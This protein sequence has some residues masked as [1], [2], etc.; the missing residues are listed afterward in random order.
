MDTPK[1][2]SLLKACIT[3]NSLKQ[4][5]LIHQKI[6]AL[7]LHHNIFLCKHLIN[8]YLSCHSFES[9][10]LVFQII[11]N[12]LDISL[13]NG[14]MASYT[15]N[16]M[17]S[18]ALQLFERLLLFPH[19]KPDNYTYPSVLK[20]C[21]GLA[22]VEN[23]KRIHTHVI[24]T[25]FGFDVVVASS[26]VGMYGKCNA[27]KLAI[28]LFYEM[29]ERDVAC[30]NTVISC[31][32]QDGQSER[33][34]ELFEE[35]RNSGFEPDSVTFTTVFSACARLF[36]LERG[37]EIHGELMR[38][39][40]ELDGFVSSAL[41]D[42]YGKCGCLDRAKEVF[43]R[44]P[45]KSVVSW[46]SMIAG[47]G[48]SGDSNS[49]LELFRRMNEEGM[50]PTLIT[51]SSLLMACSRSAKLQ[52]GKFIHGYII[53]NRIEADIFVN[54]SLIDL[55]F[56]CGS[57]GSA[58]F[59]CYFEALGIFRDMR[60]AGV[61]LDAVT[62]TSILSA[63]S[64]LA[65]LEQGR[66]I[67]NYIIGSEFES[68]EIV[69]GALLDMYAKCGAVDEALH[70]FDQLPVRDCVSWTS[71]ITAYGSHGQAIEA[72]SLFSNMQ[73][74]N[75]KPDRI[76]F[77]A[78]LSTCS[79]AGLVDEG[80]AGLVDEGCSYFN[81]MTDGYGIKPT[82]EHYSCL[83]DLL[84]RAG[85]LREAYAILQNTATLKADVGL[86][87]TL[88][89]ACNIHRDLELGEEIARLLIEKDPEDPSTYI[90][91]SNMYASVRKWEEVRKVRLKMKELGL[92]KNPGCSWIEVSERPVATE[93]I[94]FAISDCNVW[95]VCP[96][97]SL[98]KAEKRIYLFFVE[99]NSLLK[100]EMIYEEKEWVSY[101]EYG[102]MGKNSLQV[103]LNTFARDGAASEF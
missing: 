65:T 82:L 62:F 98:R 83:I 28:Q 15:K 66:E 90:I 102:N 76:T 103:N 1:L 26:L 48:S 59:G 88:F 45:R 16:Q 89:S 54:S 4:G 19:L 94:T 60:A 44:I 51:L 91:L 78:V 35:M 80:H 2:F 43:E 57:V 92:K 70:V 21:G 64:Q 17:H 24:K 6:I 97:L 101:Y 14:L 87:S 63:C 41:V 27:F 39:G 5:K 9:A 99:E 30:W 71:M 8:L 29:P 42:M 20:A 32:Y 58:E 75:A 68:N 47:Y 96:S 34:L 52:Q 95:S 50:K 53:R 74:S 81:Q 69:M 84:G 72:L 36:D 38:N 37:K 10:R 100:A 23:G 61:R 46:N 49:C 7:G 56:K 25:G 73:Q 11:E 77:L 13:W 79:H 3:H 67:H 85:R 22:N 31:Y 12:P 40:F 18:E 55:Y 33:A 93:T 86:L